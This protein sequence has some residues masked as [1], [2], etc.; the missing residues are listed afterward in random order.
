VAPAI[1]RPTS[2]S[3][4]WLN[5]YYHRLESWMEATVSEETDD[6]PSAVALI[7]SPSVL[8]PLDPSNPLPPL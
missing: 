2:N 8:L 5:G 7:L 6:V 3:R 4:H 1:V